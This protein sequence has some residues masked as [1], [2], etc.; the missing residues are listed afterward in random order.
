[1]PLTSEDRELIARLRD[2]GRVV[3]PVD[4]RVT[5]VTYYRQGNFTI[6]LATITTGNGKASAKTPAKAAMARRDLIAVGISKRNCNDDL[7]NPRRG[8]DIALTRA[9]RGDAKPIMD[10]TVAL[11]T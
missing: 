1:M 3:L 10:P 11:A 9:L 4:Q 8:A 5:D 2:S 6:A 7:E